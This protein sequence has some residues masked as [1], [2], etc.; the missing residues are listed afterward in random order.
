MTFRILILITGILFVYSSIAF[1]IYQL[2]VK[3]GSYYSARA[4]SQY[5]LAGFLEPK[6]GNIYFTDKNGNL[7]PAA[8]NKKYPVIF[9]VPAEIDDPEATAKILSEILGADENKILF[10]LTKENDLYEFLASKAGGDQIAKIREANLAGIYIDSQELRFYPFGQLAAHLLGFVGSSDKDSDLSGRYGLELYYENDLKGEAGSIEGDKATEP[11]PGK[12][13][14]LTIDRNIQARAEEILAALV[15]QYSA[16][17]GSVIVQEP[18][19]GKILAMGSFPDFDPNDYSKYDI[20]S[21]LNPVAQAV[22]EPGSIFKVITMAAGIDSGKI[23]PETKFFDSGSVTLN[24]RT[25]QNWDLE[26]YGPHGWVTMTEVIENS[27]NTGAVFA[28]RQTGR[29]IFYNYLVKFGFDEIT[30]INL[31]GEVGGNLRNLANNTRDINFA[32]ASFGQGISITP[33]E[34]INAIS[35]TANKG[36][37][38]KP[39]FIQGTEPEIVRRVISA[40]TAE[41]VSKM[42]A[43]AVAK[44]QIAQIPGYTIAGKTGTAQ[45]PD[46]RNG[47][48]TDQVINT[49]VGFAPAYDA[50]FVI[51]IKLDKPAGAPLAGL[52]VVPAFR[53]LAQFILNY[54]NIG[55]DNLTRVESP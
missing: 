19:T 18:S 41:K 42:M 24:G 7:I 22:Y 15:N 10:S 2:Q 38:M 30:E 28:Q 44:A 35:A 25:I 26:K 16:A 12:D 33:M 48:Y 34:L 23:T 13:V 20:K 27:I 39:H 43:S 9:A 37:L 1:N 11:T 6:R 53:E 55:P 21:F 3:N 54:Y 45:V 49:Y 51:L 29:D 8:I 32:T 31:P 17:G 50:K 47:G 46:F 36:I 5:R 52:T 14:I 40:E 4:E